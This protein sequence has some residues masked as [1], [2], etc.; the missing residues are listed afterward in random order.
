[1]K[2]KGFEV[3]Y[4]R[5]LRSL[6][7]RRTSPVE[8]RKSARLAA[9]MDT[10]ERYSASPIYEVYNRLGDEGSAVRYTVG[11]MQRVDPRYTEITFEEG[12]R[13]KSQLNKHYVATKLTCDFEYQGSVTSD[14]H[15][16]SHSD[17][18]L[19]VLTCR[20]TMLEWPQT[21]AQRYDG[22]PIADL[23]EI[24][25]V[26]CECVRSEFP[27]AEVDDSGAKSISVKGGS[28]RR[29]VDIVPANWYD[30]NSYA[31]S[32]A[33]RDRAVQVLDN[34]T[35]ELIKNSPFL[36]NYLIAEKD[37]QVGGGLRKV[38]RLMK[39]LKYDS[40]TIDLTSY[41]LTSIGYGMPDQDLSTFPG[42]ELALL[43][44]LKTYL[45]FVAV[46]HE[47]RLALLVPDRSRKVFCKG[48]A[49]VE[50]LDSLRSEV[51]D[52]VEAVQWNLQKSFAK[53]A[54]ARVSY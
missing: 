43:A 2:M 41:D 53:L 4:D 37:S 35:G 1:M 21:P 23:R 30:T 36:H 16:K 18:D 29:K 52:L 44:R 25:T 47:F 38:V 48:H 3:D 54:E 10:V 40:G 22:D 8:M 6:I 51:D 24:R 13:V 32:K 31:E 39:S 49:T 7:Q 26:S 33:K 28:L 15:I 42:G 46:N 14:T 9:G 34:R 19:L 20:F 11:A 50:G 5:R 12:E 45:D 27:A 17:I